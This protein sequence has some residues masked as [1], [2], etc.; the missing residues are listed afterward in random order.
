MSGISPR[1]ALERKPA[2]VK[3]QIKGP[4]LGILAKWIAETQATTGAEVG[5][6]SGFSSAFIYAALSKNSNDAKIYSFDIAEVCY[7]DSK[8]KTGD[9]FAEIHGSTDGFHL[10]TNITS[11]DISDLPRLDFLFIDGS[12]STPWPAFDILS[13]GRFL[14]PGG[15]IALDDDD[16]VFSPRFRFGTING[17]RDIY[18]TWD[19]PKTQY[20]GIRSMVILHDVT[21]SIIAR[22]V[23]RS[24][25]ID[26]E[27]RIPRD[28]LKRFMA[29]ADWYGKPH[30]GLIKRAIRAQKATKKNWQPVTRPKNLRLR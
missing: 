11:E 12:H 20:D 28:K 17:A 4:E 9:A 25:W 14:K 7:F 29:I 5:V 21:P 22:S 18:R 1:E 3:R 2:W 10:K 26:W 13:L 8:R 24:L 15:W 30:A 19:G 16:M 23:L 6:A 27:V